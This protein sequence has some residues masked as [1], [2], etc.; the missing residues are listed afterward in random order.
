MAE[1]TPAPAEKPA[2]PITDLDTVAR[3]GAQR[4]KFK[5]AAARLTTER[6]ALAKEL[7]EIK[8]RPAD[9]T[10]TQLRAELRE[11]KHRLVFDKIATELKARPEALNDLYKLSGYTPETDIADEEA[12]KGV[13]AEQ[14]KSRG[15]LFGEVATNG[16][17]T[18]T[19]APIV[20][21]GVGTG[22]GKSPAG[23]PQLSLHDP[24]D[25]S[26]WY[27]SFDKIAAA[28]KERIARGEV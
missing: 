4:R 10:A 28:A 13:I 19:P 21:P 27:K 8:A 24:S 7:A 12:I 2:M 11:I 5:D 20:K 17:D 1:K 18:G 9:P 16:L 15:Y 26:F 14:A 23:A 6:D 25:V 3:L 22:Q